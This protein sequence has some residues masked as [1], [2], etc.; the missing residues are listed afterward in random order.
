MQVKYDQHFLINEEILNIII[1]NSQINSEDIILEIGP[2]KGILTKKL[3]KENPKKLIAIELD[4]EFEKELEELEKENFIFHLEIGNALEKLDKFEYNK[5]IANIPYSITE[6]LYKNL[7][8]EKVNFS[9]LLHG[10][11]FYKNII[12]RNTKWKYYIPSFFN[13]KL[14]KEIPG[15]N[16]NPPTK[17]NSVLLK[18]E[19][20]KEITKKEEFFQNLYSKETRTLKNA[21]IFS[22]VDTL[23]KPKTETKQFLETLNIPEN[24]INT[25]LSQIDNDTFCL[26]SEEIIKKYF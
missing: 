8:K 20:K 19:Y 4:K 16:F 14:I 13:I 25:L 1:N 9:I 22:L 26:I 18:L 21:F 7:I 3:L 10:I 11:D 24:K 6:P 5:I 15:N 17:V 23:K 12:Q 2:G